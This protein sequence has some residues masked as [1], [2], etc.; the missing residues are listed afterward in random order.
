MAKTRLSA[1]VAL[2]SSGLLG[3]SGRAQAGSLQGEAPGKGDWLEDMGL[4]AW[5]IMLTLLEDES[6]EVNFFYLD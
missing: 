1:A 3:L 2:Q 5:L 6:E 4:Q